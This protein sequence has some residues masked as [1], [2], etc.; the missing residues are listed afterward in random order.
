MGHADRRLT[1][2]TLPILA[3]AC[4]VLFLG[5]AA[6]LT[7]PALPA[8]AADTYRRAFDAMPHLSSDELALLTS[9]TPRAEAAS[10]ALAARWDGALKLLH[11][12]TAVPDCDWGIDYSAKGPGTAIPHLAAARDLGRAACFR[13]RLAWEK[14]DRESA[15][16]DLRDTVIL[17]RRIG[18][19][20]KD[21]LIGSLVEVS[22]EKMV[23]KIC[24]AR[25][26]DAQDAHALNSLVMEFASGPQQNLMARA[27]QAEK[28]CFIP[29]FRR[30]WQK[31]ADAPHIVEQFGHLP[32][33]DMPQWLDDAEKTFDTVAKVMEEAPAN[34]AVRWDPVMKDIRARNNP[35]TAVVLPAGDK[36]YDHE[37]QLRMEWGLLRSGMALLKGGAEALP[38]NPDPFG[39]PLD[40]RKLDAGFELS[41]KLASSD[42]PTVLVFGAPEKPY[43]RKA[44][45]SP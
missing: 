42:A 10:E 25:L 44:N 41:G 13:A 1:G 22:L 7:Q 16:R 6:A 15:V 21:G 36:A 11:A 40:Y 2:Q 37:M 29:W 8:N 38:A 23:I 12:A 31:N 43:V 5:A 9:V 24:A 14:G 27:V 20:G 28:N 39:N 26:T 35:L 45:P 19:N 3:A 4:A 34:F 30:E 17:A 18:N 32:L 33:Q